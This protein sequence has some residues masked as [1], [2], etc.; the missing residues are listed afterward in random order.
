[1]WPFKEKKAK[2]EEPAKRL[3]LRKD[4]DLFGTY[5]VVEPNTDL[6]DLIAIQDWVKE[7]DALHYVSL[8]VVDISGRADR[9]G[10][11]YICID[12]SGLVFNNNGPHES[13][14]ELTINLRPYMAWYNVAPKTIEIAGK[15]YDRDEAIKA[16]SELTPKD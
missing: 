3:C 5:I 6:D 9:E 11:T 12:E 8:P 1:M 15:R 14:R 13:W 2:A 7:H 10:K 4:H 16:L